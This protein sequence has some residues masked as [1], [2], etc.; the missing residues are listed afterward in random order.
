V[1][2]PVG[3]TASEPVPDRQRHEHGGDRVRPH[4]RRRAEEGREQTSGRDLAP[5]ARGADDEDE[6][7]QQ[8]DLG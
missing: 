5:Q 8:S 6:Q 1:R 3:Q 7:L 4:D 2:V